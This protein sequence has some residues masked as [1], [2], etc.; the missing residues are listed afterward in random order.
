M[1]YFGGDW[2]IQKIDILVKYAKAYLEIMKK[3]NYLELMYFD[4]FAGSGYITRNSESKNDIIFGAAKQII[5]INH[6]R[7]FDAFYFVEKDPNV[8]Q[9][10][11]KNIKDAHPNKVIYCKCEDCNKKLIDLSS[12][13]RNPNNKNKRI[14]AFIDPYGLQV[15]WKTIE[16]LKGLSIDMWMLVPTGIGA[17]RLLPKNGI[18]TDAWIKKLET[19]FGLSENEIRDY[20]YFEKD[21]LFEEVTFVEKQ[22]D[23]IGKLAELYKSR[24]KN[25]FGNVSEPFVLKNSTNSIMYHLFFASNNQVARNI[26]N[27]IIKKYNK[28]NGTLF[29]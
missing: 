16:S 18:I 8:H 25:I 3:R 13:L 17:N 4:G 9:Q 28:Q 27:D 20:F 11:I 7:P 5:E 14:L 29:D 23:S 12:Y 15:E 1:N 26:A 22:K 10:L 21:T 2:T 6:P 19:F 24:L